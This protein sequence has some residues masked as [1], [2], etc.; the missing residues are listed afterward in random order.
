MRDFLARWRVPLG[1]VCGPI[2]FALA[3][4]TRG[5]IAAGVLVALLGE[6]VRVW[7]AG[8][9]RKLHEVSSSGPYRFVAHPLYLGSS[10]IGAGFA[11][12]CRSAPAALVIAAYLALT[13]SAAIAREE[14]FLRVRFGDDYDRYRSGLL[15]NRGEGRGRFSVGEAMRNREHRTMLGLAIAVLLLVLKAIFWTGSV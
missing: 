7:A 9:L 11:I 4:P 12:A 15:G 13:L 1:F 14:A 5:S 2:V 3:R 6:A 8:H 10:I